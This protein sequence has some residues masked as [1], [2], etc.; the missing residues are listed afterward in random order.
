VFTRPES[1]LVRDGLLDCSRSLLLGYAKVEPLR[2]V[3][4]MSPDE[5]AFLSRQYWLSLATASS[6][7]SVD[8]LTGAYVL[9]SET[10]IA[11]FCDELTKTVAYLNVIRNSSVV[12]SVFEHSTGTELQA[13]GQASVGELDGTEC[14]IVRYTET[15]MLQH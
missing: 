7:G 1:L 4:H 13:R 5:T 14:V 8:I 12:F 6:T 3:S 15:R 2:T 10:Q 11:V 9:I